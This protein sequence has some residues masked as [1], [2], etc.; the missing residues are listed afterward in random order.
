MKLMA[1]TLRML[2]QASAQE[3]GTVKQERTKTRKSLSMSVAQGMPVQ[4]ESITGLYAKLDSIRMKNNQNTVKLVMKATIVMEQIPKLR[5]PVLMA[6]G[7]NR[8]PI[9]GQAWFLP[10][11][12]FTVLIT[13]AME[14]YLT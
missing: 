8:L 11:T 13:K 3:D 12:T 14:T 2:V 5:L 1:P 4:L 7:A 9:Q 6:S 10:M